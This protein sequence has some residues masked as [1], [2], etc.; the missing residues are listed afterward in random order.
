MSETQALA[1]YLVTGRIQDIPDDVRHEAKRAILN[2]VGCALGGSREPAVDAA[3]KA[4]L[5]Y[6]GN[7]AASILG[8]SERADPLHASLLNGIASHVHDYDDTTPK[9]YIHPSSPV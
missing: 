5:P 6:S 1:S 8:R 9:N 7:P 3:M 2:Y 4:F